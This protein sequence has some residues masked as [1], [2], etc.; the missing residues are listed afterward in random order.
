[1]YLISRLRAGVFLSGPI[2]KCQFSV[3]IPARNTPAWQDAFQTL[4][5]K[6]QAGRN[7]RMGW[8][9]DSHLGEGV[10]VKGDLNNCCSENMKRS[11]GQDLSFY[12]LFLGNLIKQWLLTYSPLST[13][14]SPLSTLHFQFSTFHFPF[15]IALMNFFPPLHFVNCTILKLSPITFGTK[16]L[17]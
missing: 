9:W 2:L 17:Y 10:P 8:F 14:H 5:A 12:V 13:F 15:S 1:M 4:M 16:S 11:S 7:D 6:G 3:W